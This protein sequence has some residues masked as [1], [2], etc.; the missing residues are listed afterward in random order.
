VEAGADLTRRDGIYHG[1]TLGWA[2]C[3]KREEIA[4]YLRGR[5]AY[6]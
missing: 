6:T 5:G 4:A 1:T 2:E 3:E